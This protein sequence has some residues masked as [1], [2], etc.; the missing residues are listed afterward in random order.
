[1]Y[2]YV[3]A[4]GFESDTGRTMALIYF[5]TL[6]IIGNTIML[7]L[8]TALLLKSQESDI[9]RLKDVIDK[10][11]SRTA[12][13]QLSSEIVEIQK[14]ETPCDKIKGCCN[15]KACSE[16]LSSFSDSFVRIFG[17]DSALDKLQKKRR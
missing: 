7:A 8:F 2:L 17:G 6:F 3:R 12:T 13:K 5:I 14:E 9:A 16:R 11:E 10:K 15:R 1:M 4:L